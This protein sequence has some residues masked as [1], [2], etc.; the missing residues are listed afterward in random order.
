MTSILS[1]I[2][3]NINAVTYS[4]DIDN[5]TQGT[6]S[7]LQDR[8]G[9]FTASKAGD[10]MQTGKSK[11]QLFGTKA[12][13]YI[14]AKVAEIL[15]GSSHIVTSQAME[16][17]TDF[18]D[19]ARAVYEEV[20]SNKVDSVGFIPFGEFAGGSP[21]GLVGKEGIIEIKCP[22]NPANHIQTIL[23][24]QVVNKDYQ[25]QIQMNLLATNRKWC[26]FISYDPRVQEED[27]KIHIIRVDRD[28][29][30][31]TALSERLAVVIDRMQTLLK[32]AQEKGLTY[33]M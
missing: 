29:A 17:G 20:S 4:E 14:Y 32:M 26:D 28:E 2:E 16:W 6:E 13:N 33:G 19:E 10:W 5:P 3:Q 9:K 15:T 12:T 11:D 21:D 31:T 22:F 8:N 25:F 30:V 1:H 18:E 23:E 24:N 7:W 27:L